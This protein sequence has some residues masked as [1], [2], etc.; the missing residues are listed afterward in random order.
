MKQSDG[1]VMFREPDPKTQTTQLTGFS[2][3]ANVTSISRSMGKTSV[4]GL[5]TVVDRIVDDHDAC[6]LV[7]FM[8]KHRRAALP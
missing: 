8:R 5:E 1:L 3:V 2:I 6:A 7:R 4:A